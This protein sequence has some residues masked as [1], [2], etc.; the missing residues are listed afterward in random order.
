V[1]NIA[2][3]EYAAMKAGLL[4][5]KNNENECWAG[6]SIANGATE[7]SGRTHWS[8]GGFVYEWSLTS[9]TLMRSRVR[10]GFK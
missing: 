5:L 9:I 8:R 7:S 10:A 3:E 6:K 2:R 1:S 4:R